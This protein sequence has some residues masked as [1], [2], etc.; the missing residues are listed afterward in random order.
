[1]LHNETLALQ[2]VKAGDLS[3][4]VAIVQSASVRMKGENFSNASRRALPA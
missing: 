1:M 3:E 2:D 4:Q